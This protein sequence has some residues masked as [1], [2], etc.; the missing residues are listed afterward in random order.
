MMMPS[1]ATFSGAVHG[2]DMRQDMCVETCVGMHPVDE[3]TNNCFFLLDK[4]NDVS[5]CSWVS[6]MHPGKRYRRG[7]TR[8]NRLDEGS[9]T[10][11]YY[12]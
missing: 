9:P 12:L 11:P 3:W 6:V 8:W 2:T 7:G 1:R 4:K 10:V 5:G